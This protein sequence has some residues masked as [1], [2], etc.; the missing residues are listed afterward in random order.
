MSRREYRLSPFDV[1]DDYFHWLCDKVGV[2]LGPDFAYNTLLYIFYET[3][4]YWTIRNDGNR[5]SDGKYLRYE[6][7][8]LYPSQEAEEVKLYLNGRCSV[9]EML[10][11]LAIKFEDI[12]YDYECGDRTYERFFE[13][14]DNLGLMWFT[15]DQ[16]MHGDMEREARNIVQ[17]MMERKYDSMGHGSLFPTEKKRG[18][19]RRNM[20]IWDQMQRYIIENY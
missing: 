17:E 12:T 6:F 11:A 18:E 2:R 7:E 8:Q 19:D 4:F 14:I 10:V 13:M 16:L 20:E 15:D 5:A 9:L 3:P 1:T